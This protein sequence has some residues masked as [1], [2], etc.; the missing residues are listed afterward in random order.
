MF[1]YDVRLGN[2]P[3]IAECGKLK[4][5]GFGTPAVEFMALAEA[6]EDPK[7]ADFKLPTLSTPRYND[8]SLLSGRWASASVM[9]LRQLL[10]EIGLGAMVKDPTVIYTDSKGALDWMRFRKVSPAN[11]Y[12]LIAYHQKNEWIQSKDIELKYKRTNFN[13]ADLLTKAVSRQVINK[14][15]LKFLGYE[16]TIPGE[17]TDDAV[18]CEAWGR[19]VGTIRERLVRWKLSAAVAYGK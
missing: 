1:G 5:T 15:L 8:V 16:L 6:I 18:A 11:H 7:L 13:T 10:R 12:I 3:V 17:S 19:E 2:G 4:N 9:W 14:L